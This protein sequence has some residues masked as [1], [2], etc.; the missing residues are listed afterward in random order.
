[1]LVDN[2]QM[3][4]EVLIGRIHGGVNYACMRT[5]LVHGGET[6]CKHGMLVVAE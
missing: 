2:D 6:M 1:M 5:E 4:N 3:P